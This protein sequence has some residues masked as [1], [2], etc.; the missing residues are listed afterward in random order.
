MHL[1]E[2]NLLRDWDGLQDKWKCRLRNSRWLRRRRRCWPSARPRSPRSPCPGTSPVVE[3]AIVYRFTKQS[4]F[5]SQRFRVWPTPATG[6][7]DSHNL[8]GRNVLY[9]GEIR[10][11]SYQSLQ[12]ARV[13]VFGKLW[14]LK[15]I[16]R[17]S[18]LKKIWIFGSFYYS[19]Y[20]CW[21]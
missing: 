9:S 20:S 4:T 17:V 16:F 6:A 18:W 8:L 10:A 12:D 7:I 15:F 1:G 19:F 2:S 21:K 13:R 11:V 5:N 3:N 14:R